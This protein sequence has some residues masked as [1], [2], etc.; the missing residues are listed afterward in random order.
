[1]IRGNAFII[2]NERELRNFRETSWTQTGM[3]T[4]SS[5]RNDAPYGTSMDA[6]ISP[7]VQGFLQHTPTLEGQIAFGAL[8]RTLSPTEIERH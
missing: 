1:M 3:G 6:S 5:L 8:D 2:L 4:F 7:K